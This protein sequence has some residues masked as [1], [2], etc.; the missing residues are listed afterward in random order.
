V[1]IFDS[2]PGIPP[3]KLKEI[4]A[5]FFSTRKGRMGLGFTI[6]RTNIEAH[7]GQIWAENAPRGGA[8]FH[9]KLPLAMLSN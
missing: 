3:D 7:D 6:A 4:F 5:P 2:G 9:I 8:V 1:S